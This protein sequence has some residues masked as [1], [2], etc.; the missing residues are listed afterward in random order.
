[1]TNIRNFLRGD[2]KQKLPENQNQNWNLI[3]KKQKHF[4]FFLE[5]LFLLACYFRPSM[6]SLGKRRRASKCWNK[7]K[8]ASTAER[9]FATIQ[10]KAFNQPIQGSSRSQLQYLKLWFNP[11]TRTKR[12]NTLETSQQIYFCKGRRQKA[13]YRLILRQKPLQW[14][15]DQSASRKS[16][17]SEDNFLV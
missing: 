8:G 10:K 17:K 14:L 11:R 7:T 16:T 3:S 5:I 13:V 4:F 9:R 1:M 12:L 6:V 2:L 15:I